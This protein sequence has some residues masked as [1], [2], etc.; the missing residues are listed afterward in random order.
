MKNKIYEG[1]IEA[2]EENISVLNLLIEKDK[3]KKLSEDFE[4]VLLG[5]L[6][7]LYTVGGI[8]DERKVKYTNEQQ[9]DLFKIVR[10][11]EHVL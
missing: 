5:I 8:V 11:I 10:E 2:G 1:I 4:K 7:R 3:Y 9:I 6:D